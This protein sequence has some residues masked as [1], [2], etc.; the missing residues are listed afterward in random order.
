MQGMHALFR[1]I[2][3]G[4]GDNRSADE[5]GDPRRARL[6]VEGVPSKSYWILLVPLPGFAD[7]EGHAERPFSSAQPTGY[8]ERRLVR[9][10]N[11]ITVEGRKSAM[12]FR[13]VFAFSMWADGKVPA[14]GNY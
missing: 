6:H 10:K 12:H 2:K 7:I 9:E 1:I 13:P 11:G 4:S 14:R 3:N 8:L 5:A